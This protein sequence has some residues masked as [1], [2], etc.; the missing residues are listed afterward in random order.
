MSELLPS[1]PAPDCEATGYR[2]S[3]IALADKVV[4]ALMGAGWCPI[5]TFAGFIA[6]LPTTSGW[7]LPYLVML[8]ATAV[9]GL[10]GANLLTDTAV[11]MMGCGSRP[12]ANQHGA[13]H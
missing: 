2:E 4:L 3:F 7:S 8:L 11:D 12:G 13:L 1:L 9:M 10:G 5:M 6:L